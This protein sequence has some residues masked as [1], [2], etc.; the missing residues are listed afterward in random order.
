MVV[1]SRRWRYQAATA[2]RLARI[3]SILK[4]QRAGVPIS[5]SPNPLV[6][7][8]ATGVTT[9]YPNLEARPGAVAARIIAA[10]MPS[11]TS[12]LL[13]QAE[14]RAG[15]AVKPVNVR[16]SIAV[17]RFYRNGSVRLLALC[18]PGAGLGIN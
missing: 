5:T 8:R 13:A 7:T 4:L 14:R 15:Y 2:R 3:W 17:G 6:I 10:A 16:K 1:L 12:A 11:R 18:S 9:L